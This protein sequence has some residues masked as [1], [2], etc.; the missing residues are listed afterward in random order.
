MVNKPDFLSN[1]PEAFGLSVLVPSQQ[2]PAPQLTVV[3]A[4]FDRAAERGVPAEG[5]RL[6]LAGK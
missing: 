2:L 5:E 6:P 1:F 3:R 4:A